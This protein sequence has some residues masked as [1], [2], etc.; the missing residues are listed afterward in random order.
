MT[1]A[2]V[3]LTVLRWGPREILVTLPRDLA[4]GGYRLRV[5]RS[6]GDDEAAEF[7]VAIGIAGPPGE[8]GPPGQPGMPGLPGQP[9]LPGSPGSPG[10]PGLLGFEV[11]TQPFSM[12]IAG[13]STF[14]VPCPQGKTALGGGA[15]PFTDSAGVLASYPAPGGWALRM[16]AN[17][18]ANGVVYALCAQI[19]DAPSCSDMDGDGFP[20]ESACGAADCDDTR[21][22]VHPGAADVCDGAD[23]DCDGQTDENCA[24]VPPEP[25]VARLSVVP[26]LLSV[27]LSVGACVPRSSIGR[28][29]GGFLG[30]G[31]EF[32]GTPGCSGGATGCQL[33]PT[34]AAGGVFLEKRTNARLFIRTQLDTIL[35]IPIKGQLLGVG[36]S[37]SL[38]AVVQNATIDAMV[39]YTYNEATDTFRL[40]RVDSIDIVNLNP[41]FSNCGFLE[42][43]AG[44]ATNVADTLQVTIVQ[45]YVPS[46]VGI[47]F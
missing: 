35:N 46:L 37:C 26:G 42:D 23:N 8:P 9:G 10:D 22:D 3:G 28:P 38:Q 16:G 45:L 41:S 6:H 40:S 34:V 39:S 12:A 15:N 18:A 2:G 27:R 7:D 1:L 4:P 29:S 25:S 5:S 14:T 21:S 33:S 30:T 24:S 17:A 32:C 44:L 36:F 43:I 13:T 11:V 19:P 31:A 47:E 20:A